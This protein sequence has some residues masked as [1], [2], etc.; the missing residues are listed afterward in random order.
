METKEKIRSK[1]D[2]SEVVDNVPG[3][4]ARALARMKNMMTKRNLLIVLFVILAIGFAY[5]FI[6]YRKL[7]KSPAEMAREKTEHVVKK[8]S[9][10]VVVPND[11]NTTLATVT[12]ITKLKGQVFF[13]DA[14]NGDQV[15]LFPSKM[16]AILYRP[17]I[18]KIINIGPLSSSPDGATT[19]APAPTKPAATTTTTKKP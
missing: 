7:S 5:Y 3:K 16:I 2:L 9:Q 14:K 1:K 6:Q 17:S 18:D 15:I 4:K 12:D 19:P 10:H 13:A 11:P 8:V